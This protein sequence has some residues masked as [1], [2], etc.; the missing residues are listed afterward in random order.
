M[1]PPH[2]PRVPQTPRK[3]LIHIN[4]DSLLSFETSPRFH[5]P[6][7]V[8]N[9]VEI[10]KNPLKSETIPHP[11]LGQTMISQITNHLYLWGLY[12]PPAT[13]VLPP[14]GPG[15]VAN[16]A[17]ENN[18]W[19]STSDRHGSHWSRMLPRPKGSL[20]NSRWPMIYNCDMHLWFTTMI[21]NHVIYVHLW[22]TAVISTYDTQLWYTTYVFSVHLWYTTKDCTPHIAAHSMRFP[23]LGN[24]RW[25]SGPRYGTK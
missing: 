11:L 13:L 21:Y 18:D 2:R 9:K 1:S 5:S 17:D 20:G 3:T 19:D 23:C 6:N 4:R 24:S 22:Y 10:H 14:R 8:L 7:S 25:P 12:A 16:T 15:T